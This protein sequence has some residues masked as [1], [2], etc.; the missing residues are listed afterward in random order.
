MLLFLIVYKPV[1][2][3]NHSTIRIGDYL[4][5]WGGEQANFPDVHNSE[6]KRS[7]SSVIEIF[8]LPTGVWEQKP[9]TGNPPLG[10]KGYASAF[11]GKEIF[12]FGGY[13][14][15]DYCYHN[16]LYSLNIDTFHWTEISPTIYNDDH[17]MMKAFCGMIAIKLDEEDYLAVIGGYG[18]TSDDK[19]THGAHCN[20][21]EHFDE[22]HLYKLSSGQYGFTRTYIRA[23]VSV[24]IVC[25]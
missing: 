3:E 21:C 18:P 23:K 1:E 16:S 7:L 15:H 22:I 25:C 13:C 4:Y 11:I 9:T 17:P 2:R 10:I 24:I 8:H 19:P 12:Y 5:M 20:N 14:N 6:K